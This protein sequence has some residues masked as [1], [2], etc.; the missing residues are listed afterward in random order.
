MPRK[1]LRVSHVSITLNDQSADME[2]RL[3]VAVGELE[4]LIREK[5]H[6]IPYQAKAIF[7]RDVVALL[8]ETF[9]KAN[10][11]TF[12]KAIQ[13]DRTF[14]RPDGGLFYVMDQAGLKRYILVA[15]AK[16]Q[17]TNDLRQAEGKSKQAQG[18]A[19]ERLRKNM[20]GIDC[21]FAA[22]AITPF[23]CF[24][25]G[26]DF[27]SDSSSLDRVATMNSF[28]P[29]S[30]IYID[31]IYVTQPVQE[32]FKPTSLY[33]REAPW[34][35]AEMLDVMWTICQR[36]IEYYDRKY[37]LRRIAPK[38]DDEGTAEDTP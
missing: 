26:L 14:L 31:K 16:R 1:A 28:F 34:M 4:R 25:E 7:L 18:N 8:N 36:S 15:E 32:I 20:Q 17:G 30:T 6:V 24:G 21:L 5:Y 13:N 37:G 23:V 12:T 33:F 10:G 35:P 2:D 38:S 9:G 29:L 11:L 19:V 3:A 27:A 22:E